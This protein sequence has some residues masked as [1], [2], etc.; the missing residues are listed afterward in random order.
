[1][2]IQY[3][4]TIN[5]CCLFI[6]YTSVFVVIVFGDWIEIPQVNKFQT[7]YHYNKPIPT[8]PRS[9]SS[10]IVPDYKQLFTTTTEEKLRE[11]NVNWKLEQEQQQ[12][13]VGAAATTTD[14]F[15]LI[16]TEPFSNNNDYDSTTVTTTITNDDDQIMFVNNGNVNGGNTRSQIIT[17]KKPDFAD[18]R[19]FVG[20]DNMNNNGGRKET[21]INKPEVAFYYFFFNN[22]ILFSIC[23]SN[24]K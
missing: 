5:Q 13:R 14:S 6:I 8:T 15:Y 22:Q 2:L 20:V 3:S 16:S 12:Q 24:K 11:P 7:R 1:M 23:I 21:Q 17:S 10:P 19:N 4:L 9:P 18:N